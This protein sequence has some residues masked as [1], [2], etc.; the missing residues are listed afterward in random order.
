MAYKK[1][2]NIGDLKSSIAFTSNTDE[3]YL[4][5]QTG[6]TLLEGQYD[7]KQEIEIK[8]K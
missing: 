7:F 1:N 6:T 5:N 2:N 8:K 3:T 4:E